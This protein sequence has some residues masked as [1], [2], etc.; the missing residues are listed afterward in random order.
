M[1]SS[2]V[3]ASW[4]AGTS[5]DTCIVA[6]SGVGKNPGGVKATVGIGLGVVVGR[7]IAVGV[8]TTVHDTTTDKPTNKINRHGD[9]IELYSN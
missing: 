5:A 7:R 4:Q 8:A 1:G 2:N 9:F 3:L 6:L